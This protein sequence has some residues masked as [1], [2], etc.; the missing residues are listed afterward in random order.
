[1]MAT[2]LIQS[3]HGKELLN[4]LNCV[5]VRSESNDEYVIQKVQEILTLDPVA[6]RLVER[7]SGNNAFHLLV[8]KAVYFSTKTVCEILDLMRNG[9][10]NNIDGL[11]KANNDGDLPLHLY[12]LQP[13]V[14]IQVINC[15]LRHYP[16][17]ASFASQ[18][19]LI[20][21][22]LVVMRN[23]IS[24][25]ICKALC[26]AN[27]QGPSTLNGSQSYP[28]HFAV[29]KCR[30][31]PEIIR[32]L[33]R[34]FPSALQH[35]N[36]QG[37][38]PLHLAASS[39]HNVQ[40][41]RMLVEAYPESILLKDRQGRTALHL[42]VLARAQEYQQILL[43]AEEEEQYQQQQQKDL[44]HEEED[45][46]RLT[47][48][49][50]E[51]Q[52]DE[53][54]LLTKN[55]RKVVV[56]E[57]EDKSDDDNVTDDDMDM[58]YEKEENPHSKGLK[59]PKKKTMTSSKTTSTALMNNSSSLERARFILYYLISQNPWALITP[60]NFQATPLET[61]LHHHPLPA[62]RQH[63][64]IKV[65]NLFH[66]PFTARILLCQH[67]YYYTQYHQYH[68]RLLVVRSN[69]VLSLSTSYPLIEGIENDQLR[70]PSLSLKFIQEM[71][72][73]NWHTRKWILFCSY[74][75]HYHELFSTKNTNMTVKKNPIQSQQQQQQQIF[76][77]K[78]KGN[79][80]KD[81]QQ[82]T[83]NLLMTND[84]N[85]SSI[86]NNDFQHFIHPLNLFAKLRKEGFLDILRCVTAWI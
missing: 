81:R 83:M 71:K 65:Y 30:P 57:E 15:L 43:A 12:I 25:D 38:L 9:H 46:I 60:N 10:E 48:K 44:Y 47:Q 5:T 42:A 69:Q 72:E 49:L 3:T 36:T 2:K 41:I 39:N 82:V 28:I 53:S 31:N 61:V 79:N 6:C 14:S 23:D 13:N 32:I 54:T 35:R 73:L 75:G 67:Q 17:A 26:I 4:L 1:M 24:A 21:L 45:L 8:R 11:K 86:E 78:L 50:K 33:I 55:Y 7:Q 77:K 37:S 62:K 70:W 52:I 58:D 18:F 20:P 19:Q 16:Q 68:N 64:S 85:N 80:K 59:L 84:L 66:D 76:T 51:T 56:E 74:Q 63:K 29:K 22:F 40:I 34:R 27:P